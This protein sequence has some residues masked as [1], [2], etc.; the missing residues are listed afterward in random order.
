MNLD[1]FDSG[2]ARF[3]AVE[4]VTDEDAFKVVARNLGPDATDL[5]WLKMV[6]KLR[7]GMTNPLKVAERI[8]RERGGDGTI[9]A[10]P[11]SPFNFIG[12]PTHPHTPTR[13][14]DGSVTWE[15]V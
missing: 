12:E 8:V 3:K 5:E 7:C 2:A 13:N 4:I 11:A 10:K 15:P 1:D 9:I 6:M 14:A